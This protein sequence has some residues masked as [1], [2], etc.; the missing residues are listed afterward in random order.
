LFI[1]ALVVVVLVLLLRRKKTVP[2]AA[3]PAPQAVQHTR[4]AGGEHNLAGCIAEACNTA[5]IAETK[6]TES[7]IPNARKD[8][9][10]L[11]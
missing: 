11:H 7:N 9:F 6:R 5:A 2:V 3:S 1:L 8:R 10:V 4:T